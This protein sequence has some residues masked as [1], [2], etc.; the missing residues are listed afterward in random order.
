MTTYTLE[1]LKD[2]DQEKLTKL[3]NS[4]AVELLHTDDAISNAQIP[5]CE[6]IL[7]NP[8]VISLMVP[9]PKDIYNPESVWKK[10]GRNYEFEPWVWRISSAP[11]LRI[12]RKN[13]RI[14]HGNDFF[15]ATEFIEARRKIKNRIYKRNQRSR[16]KSDS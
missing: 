10:D 14:I 3:I 4:S 9:I 16:S 8:F 5:F 6:N 2:I 15:P 11:A 1:E 13:F 7:S 12:Y